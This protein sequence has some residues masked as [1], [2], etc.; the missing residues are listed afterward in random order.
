LLRALD[1]DDRMSI[2]GL[3]VVKPYPKRTPLRSTEASAS[4]IRNFSSALPTHYPG[5]RG[6]FVDGWALTMVDPAMLRPW[7]GVGPAFDLDWGGRTWTLRLDDLRPG[8]RVQ[9]SGVGPLLALEG[10]AEVGRSAATALSG[11]T[12]VGFERRWG[13]VEATYAPLGWGGLIIRAA[14]SPAA[15]Q[16]MDLEVQATAHSIG[17]LKALEVKL[18]SVL[19]EPESKSKA[20]RSAPPKRWVEP[21]DARS[22]GLSYDGRE[23][24]VSGL[25]TLP[26]P[27]TDAGLLPRVLP[28]PWADGW[29]YAELVHPRDAARRITEAGSISSLGH[30]TR[31]GLF[32]HDVEKGVVL[33][34][35]LRGIWL[36]ADSPQQAALD[37][38]EQF[39]HEPLPLGT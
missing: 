13:R 14:W 25:T 26:P 30:T 36:R 39:L 7:G 8:L 4:F 5:R 27:A 16:G 17:A 9:G 34:A 23:A 22:A 1:K 37:R 18:V 28:S 2:L 20:A 31:Y 38:F 12:L 11:A 24:E 21:R 6:F 29:S 35:R 32:G 33:R 15:D 10:V 3:S 19:P